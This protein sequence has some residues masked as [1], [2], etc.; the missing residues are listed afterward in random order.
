VQAVTIV[1]GGAL[2]G[3]ARRA[4]G[5]GEELSALREPVGSVTIGEEAVV[6]DAMEA[7]WQDV[8]EKPADELRRLE[9]H[10]LLLVGTPRAVV[11]G[12]ER[13][14][15]L[16]DVQKSLI[17]NGDAMGIPADLVEHLLWAGERSLRIHDPL[18]LPR[19]CEVRGEGAGVGERGEGSAELEAPRVVRLLEVLEKEATE[20]S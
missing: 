5:H 20:Q 16:L 9:G 10:G 4:C 2:D 19:G 18:G 14:A 1:N 6:A 3:R 15:A 11:L 17:R 8:Q 7:R 12:A 13:D